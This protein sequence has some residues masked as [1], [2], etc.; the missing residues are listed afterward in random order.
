[1]CIICKLNLYYEIPPRV[2]LVEE[3]SRQANA[4]IHYI[5]AHPFDVRNSFSSCMPCHAMASDSAYYDTF[6]ASDTEVLVLLE[7]FDILYYQANYQAD[8]SGDHVPIKNNRKMTTTIHDD[9]NYVNIDTAV[10]TMVVTTQDL[11]IILMMTMVITK[12]DADGKRH[13]LVTTSKTSGDKNE[14]ETCPSKCCSS[15]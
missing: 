12:V 9:K 5:H 2:N 10:A 15:V 6:E 11:C 4:D 8:V 3:K 7:L 1:M 14:D 13:T